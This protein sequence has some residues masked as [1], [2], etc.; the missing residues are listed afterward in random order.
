MSETETKTGDAGASLSEGLRALLEDGQ[1]LVEAEL[2]FQKQ[3]AAYGWN[4]AKGIALLL[5]ATLFCAF[6][7]LVALVVGLLFALSTLV[8][9]W[10]ATAIMTL[11][12]TAVAGGCFFAAVGRF[13]KARAVI[14]GDKP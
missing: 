9:P 7:V 1:T 12:L 2:S 13:R 3:R 11:A 14:M 5:L 4:R 10:W 6:F 8:G